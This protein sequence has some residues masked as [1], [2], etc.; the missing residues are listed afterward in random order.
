[1]L[2]EITMRMKWVVSILGVFISCFVAS[3]NNTRE[4]QRI[5]ELSKKEHAALLGHE[6]LVSDGTLKEHFLP[7]QPRPTPAPVMFFGGQNKILYTYEANEKTTI[8]VFDVADGHSRDLVTVP[9]RVFQ[10]APSPDKRRIAFMGGPMLRVVD[11]ETGTISDIAAAW[12]FSLPAWSPDGRS[13]VFEK[14]REHDQG[15]GYSE[16]AIASLESG[17]IAVLDKGRFPSWS[18][19]GD[20]IAYT[21]VDGKQLKMSDPQGAHH[22]VLKKN[23]A[24]VNGPIEGPLVW[25]PDQKSLIFQRVHDDI[26]GEEH[27][28]IYVLD[29]AT[30]EMK[31]LASDET[32]LAWR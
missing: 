15:W 10:I 11:I 28:K 14:N 24:A 4:F 31:N 27:S 17:K 8:A 22:R 21:D 9:E 30:G 12:R 18:P 13:I 5:I 26:H 1:M 3:A 19:K 2:V 16:V 32:V 6:W 23:W 7:N 25:S 20:L 29:I